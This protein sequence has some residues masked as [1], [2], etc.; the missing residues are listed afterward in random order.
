M[1]DQQISDLLGQ[2][3]KLRAR[4]D[5]A[6]RL[7]ST[8]TSISDSEIALSEALDADREANWIEA[9]LAGRNVNRASHG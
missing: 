4:A 7:A 1:V 3:A 6:R 8:L 5:R 9:E 2:L